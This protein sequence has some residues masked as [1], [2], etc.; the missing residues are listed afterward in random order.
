[1]RYL[2]VLFVMLALL[3]L[4]EPV[5]AG[6]IRGQVV[7]GNGAPAGNVA[8]VLSGPQNVSTTTNGA[9]FYEF[10]NLPAGR[11][12]ISVGGQSMSVIVPAQGVTERNI[13]VP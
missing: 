10:K 9:G 4:V 7:R 6:E 11:Y 3:M 13:Q 8:I 2:S 12:T 5:F 1:M